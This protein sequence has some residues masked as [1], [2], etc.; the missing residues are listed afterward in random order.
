MTS[1]RRTWCP[2]A[3]WFFTVNL[4]DRRSR[5]L[6]ERIDALRD[7]FRCVRAA[8][9]FPIDA[10]V[11]LPEHLH[12]VWTLPE[13]DADF[14]MRWRLVKTRFSR[15]LPV[16]EAVSASRAARRERGIWQRR[17]WEHRIRDED[18]LCSQVDHLHYNP[19]KHGHVPRVADRPHSSF[20]RFV[21]RGWLPG[22]WGGERAAAGGSAS[23]RKVGAGGRVE[24]RAGRMGGARRR[25]SLRS[26]HPEGR[27][28]V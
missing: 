1:Y 6:I 19:V 9:P 27:R 22:D 2:G 23:G 5:L 25:I 7:A 24:R 21:E 14:A 11:V 26:T 8:H 17:C 4:A 12:A 3:T 18:D 10:I 15:A 28:M 20:H 16:G 13:G